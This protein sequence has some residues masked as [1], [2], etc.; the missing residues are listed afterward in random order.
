MFLKILN[1]I[2]QLGLMDEPV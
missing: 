1:C 2:G